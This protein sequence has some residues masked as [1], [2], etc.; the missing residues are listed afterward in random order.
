[1]SQRFFHLAFGIGLAAVLWVA[2]GFIGGS[3]LALAMTTAIAA[4]YLLGAFELRQ[5]RAGTAAL[6]AALD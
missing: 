1:M 2:F 4:A 5:F 6:A 3:W